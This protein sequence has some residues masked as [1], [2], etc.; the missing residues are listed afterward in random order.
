MKT[1]RRSLFVLLLTVGVASACT[2]SVLG[3]E[4]VPQT[5]PDPGV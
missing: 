4:D 3:P 2:T 5:H 1:L